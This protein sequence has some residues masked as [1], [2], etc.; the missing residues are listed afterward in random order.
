MPQAS[1]FGTGLA[2]AAPALAHQGRAA[3]LAG[4]RSHCCAVLPA[5]I[6]PGWGWAPARRMPS[7]TL[8]AVT[9]H[10]FSRAHQAAIPVIRPE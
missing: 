3:A 9:C 2:G 1:G 7:D 8:P 10:G 6:Q 4:Q 5:V